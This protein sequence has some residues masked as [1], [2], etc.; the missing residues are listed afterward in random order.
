MKNIHPPHHSNLFPT[1][2]DHEKLKPKKS[3]FRRPPSI[4]SRLSRRTQVGGFEGSKSNKDPSTTNRSRINH[5]YFFLSC[6]EPPLTRRTV[7]CPFPLCF[8]PPSTRVYIICQPH[9]SSTTFGVRHSL[10]LRPRDAP[11]LPHSFHIQVYYNIHACLF[12]LHFH[13][14]ASFVIHPTFTQ[15]RPQSQLPHH[16]LEFSS[17]RE[18]EREVR[19]EARSGCS[20]CV[21]RCLW[22][23][24]VHLF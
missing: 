14:S 4:A 10:R 9:Y 7:F 8:V 2:S 6:R 15:C 20:C 23:V 16:C 21:R 12:F 24:Q 5:E 13:S 22:S 1:C 17:A 11:F 3:D 19:S 18:R